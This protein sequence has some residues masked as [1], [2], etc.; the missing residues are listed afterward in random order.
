VTNILQY[1]A[2]ADDANATSVSWMYD[3]RSHPCEN[4]LTNE[5]KDYQGAALLVNNTAV[6]SDN[7]LLGFQRVG[8]GSKR[9]DQGAIGQFG[10]GSQTMYHWTDVPMIIS[11]KYMIMLE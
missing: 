7:D 8:E 1:L 5:L 10:R 3:D 6:F 9:Q 2:N 4:L 11:G